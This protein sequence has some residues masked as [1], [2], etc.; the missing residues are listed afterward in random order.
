M[1]LE[2]KEWISGAIHNHQFLKILMPRNYTLFVKARVAHILFHLN[3]IWVKVCGGFFLKLKPKNCYPNLNDVLFGI[4]Q[5]MTTVIRW[6]G[7]W[8]ESHSQGNRDD[9][10]R[11]DYHTIA[12]CETPL[13]H[14]F[15]QRANR[16]SG[17]TF[18][19][20]ILFR[21]CWICNPARLIKLENTWS[22]KARP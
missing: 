11:V 6:Q 8:T 13:L 1:V 12:K 18:L 7:Y 15:D 2:G 5:I 21:Y 3:L 16:K 4:I 19:W 22:G 10:L 20:Q 17:N 14:N 9:G